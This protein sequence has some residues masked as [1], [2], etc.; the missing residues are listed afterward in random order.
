MSLNKEVSA[1]MIIEV[2]GKPPE[3]LI[4]TLESIIKQ[5]S[6]ETGVSIIDKKINEPVLL[7]EQT[8]FYSSFAEIEIKVKEILYIARLI[9]KYMPAHIEII[10]PESVLLTNSEMNEIFN[11]TVR[12]LHEY[13]EIARILEVEKNILGKR[14]KEL[15]QKENKEIGEEK[16]I[17]ENKEKPKK[18]KSVK[19]EVE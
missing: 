8:E 12:R 10:E 1:I 3:H 2:I 11:E 6:E 16:Q 14:I 13:D 9:F 4:E 19:K 18:K 7:K 17:S 15:T 5:I